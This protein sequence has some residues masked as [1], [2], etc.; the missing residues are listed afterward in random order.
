MKNLK[1]RKEFTS[2]HRRMLDQVITIQEI[3]HT[4]KILLKHKEPRSDGLTATYY[5]CF[6][7][8]LTIPQQKTMNEIQQRKHIPPTCQG[9]NITLI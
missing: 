1:M 7:D 2:E 4:I 8:I 9:T 3:N 5:K 6:E